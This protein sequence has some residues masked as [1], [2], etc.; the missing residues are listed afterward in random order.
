MIT[1]ISRVCSVLA[2][3]RPSVALAGLYNLTEKHTVYSPV[4]KTQSKIN[5]VKLYRSCVLGP[6]PELL[7]QS[8]HIDW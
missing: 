4:T 2:L 7:I 6:T 1:L 5:L 8:Y 3:L